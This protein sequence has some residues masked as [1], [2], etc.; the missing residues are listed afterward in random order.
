MDKRKAEMACSEWEGDGASD[1]EAFFASLE[2]AKPLTILAIEAGQKKSGNGLLRTA[3]HWSSRRR[4]AF[5]FDRESE[6]T[7]GSSH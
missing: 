2:E 6:M 3:G 5:C 7:G 4:S 1:I